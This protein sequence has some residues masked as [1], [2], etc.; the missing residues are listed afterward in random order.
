MPCAGAG[1]KRYANANTKRSISF[2][3]NLASASWPLGLMTRRRPSDPKLVSVSLFFL[4][5]PSTSRKQIRV[6][7]RLLCSGIPLHSNCRA[8][9]SQKRSLGGPNSFPLRLTASNHLTLH[10]P[11]T[12]KDPFQNQQSQ[13]GT[14]CS[15]ITSASHAEG[16]GFKSQCVHLK[17]GA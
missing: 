17:G 5:G 1:Q 6:R 7:W 9:R 4:Q 16:P 2:R 12:S 13:M 10:A 15:G 14:W 11:K 8:F 3:V